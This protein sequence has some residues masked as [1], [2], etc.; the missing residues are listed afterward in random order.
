M[1]FF[2]IV[3]GCT[4]SIILVSINGGGSLEDTGIAAVD[5]AGIISA[6][7]VLPKIIAE[8]LF[9]VD[10]ESNMLKMVQSMQ[11]NDASIRNVLYKLED[12]TDI[13]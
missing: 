6:L 11:D 3:A 7:V 9:P 1:L 2:G 5:A 13:N 10:E 8:H 4:S 12:D